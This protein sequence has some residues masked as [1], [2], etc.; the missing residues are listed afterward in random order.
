MAGREQRQGRQVRRRRL[1]LDQHH[2]RTFKSRPSRLTI[3]A[4]PAKRR[5]RPIFPSTR[6]T[7]RHFGLLFSSCV[8]DDVSVSLR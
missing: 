3:A 8:S 6:S 5:N 2:H 1:D 4:I 7:G